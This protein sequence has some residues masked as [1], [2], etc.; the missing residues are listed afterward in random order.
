MAGPTQGPMKWQNLDAEDFD[1]EGL[2]PVESPVEPE[3]LEEPELLDEEL[4]PVLTVTEGVSGSGLASRLVPAAALVVLSLGVLVWFKLVPER[5][6][7]TEVAE[8]V[9]PVP[10][11]KVPEAKPAEPKAEAPALEVEA[12]AEERPKIVAPGNPID[13]MA[14][15][16]KP[17]DVADDIAKEAERKKAEVE[18]LEEIKKNQ[19]D[20]LKK[21]PPPPEPMFRGRGRGIPPE[22]LKKFMEMQQKMHEEMVNRMMGRHRDF[23]ANAARGFD[24][25]FEQMEKQFQRDV[26]EMNRMMPQGRLMPMLPRGGMPNR[27]NRNNNNGN[28]NQPIIRQFNGPNGSG[29]I[30][31][32]RGGM[33][34]RN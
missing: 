29:V 3:I 6:P 18:K 32:W 27:N 19:A 4:V 26:E 16:P 10:A 12:K 31:Q 25:M 17:K 11:P 22:E 21:N 23:Q 28:N 8:R 14:P 5:R 20:D 33:M 15:A 1:L 9:A 30:I 34:G 7:A 2:I 13:P 24:E